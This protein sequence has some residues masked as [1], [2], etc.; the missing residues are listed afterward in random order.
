MTFK[1]SNFETTFL[2]IT[3]KLQI[4]P[5]THSA[6]VNSH[7]IS[8]FHDPFTTV[9]LETQLEVYLNVLFQVA[10]V[11]RFF[12]ANSAIV[13][14]FWIFG[15]DQNVINSFVQ[16]FQ[17]GKLWGVHCIGFIIFST[18]FLVLEFNKLSTY[19]M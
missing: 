1:F 17:S 9:A 13:S 8:C 15:V 2:F 4:V 14:S 3:A 16:F 18:H 19:Y 6:D 10:P 11:P 12:V 7:G 5:R